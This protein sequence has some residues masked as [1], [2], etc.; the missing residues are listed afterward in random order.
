MKSMVVIIN[1]LTIVYSLRLF[2]R[3]KTMQSIFRRH[4]S[5][6]FEIVYIFWYTMMV[7]VGDVT[8]TFNNKSIHHDRTGVKHTHSLS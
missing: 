7:F 3:V 2:W 1:S 8:S 4:A 6:Y 5:G